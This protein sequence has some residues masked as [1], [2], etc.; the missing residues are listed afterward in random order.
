MALRRTRAVVLMAAALLGLVRA[1]CVADA[2]E[3]RATRSDARPL[4]ALSCASTSCH[5]SPAR[6]SHLRISQQEFSVWSE[7]D[8]HARFSRTL[9]SPAF[10]QIVRRL[11]GEDPQRTQAVQERCAACHDPLA[12]SRA[13]DGSAPRGMSCETCHGNAEHWL[14]RHYQ[15]DATWQELRGLGMID[16]KDLVVRAQLCASCHV[17]DGLRDMDHDMIAAGHPPLRFELS[18]YHDLIRHKHWSDR[19]RIERPQFKVQLWAAGQL[20]TADAALS[21]TAARAERARAGTAPWPEFAEFDC[22]ACHQRLRADASSQ[23]RTAGG[24][25]GMPRWQPWNLASAPRLLALGGMPPDGQPLGRMFVLAPDEVERQA[26]RLR[27]QLR[28]HPLAAALSNASGDVSA[29]LPVD[30]LLAWVEE[31]RDEGDHWS[32]ACQDLL[33]LKAAYL[34][35]RDQGHQTAS[36]SESASAVDH[37][38]MRDQLDDLAAALRFGSAEFEWPAFDW[39]G[40]PPA[41]RPQR[42]NYASLPEIRAKLRGLAGQLRHELSGRVPPAPATENP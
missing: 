25:P 18:A 36:G 13:T 35:L 28:E 26:S 19:E 24:D 6:P 41:Q 39:Q 12:Q 27:Q 33:A 17:G 32:A 2:A 31:S 23:R 20:A 4:G 8:P 22:F 38:E 34:V 3:Q 10:G 15:H 7:M 21:L 11:A 5:G 14:T 40:L 16:T 1:T 30:V 42:V 9:D 37:S 29:A